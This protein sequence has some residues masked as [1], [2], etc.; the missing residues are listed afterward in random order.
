MAANSDDSAPASSS[1]WRSA[2][3][4][5]FRRGW[6]RPSSP[7]GPAGQLQTVPQDVSAVSSSEREYNTSSDAGDSHSDYP[8]YEGGPPHP[9]RYGEG[10]PSIL[11]ASP[12]GGPTVPQRVWTT[13]LLQVVWQRLSVLVSLL[14]L[15]SLSQ[16]VLEAYEGLITSNVVVPLFLTMLVGAGGNAGNQAAV[17]A[18]TG[19]V[20]G[21]LRPSHLW[22]LLRREL[23]VGLISST[24]LF[25]IGFV[26]VYLYYTNEEV[27]P[28]PV[29]A[30]VFC[31]SA[32]LFMIVL[33]SVVLGTALPFVLRK[34]KFD[35]EHAAPMIQ[36]LMD[37]LGVL[38]ACTVCA[39]FLPSDVPPSQPS[40]PTPAAQQHQQ[41]QAQRSPGGVTLLRHH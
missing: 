8:S 6:I 4:L 36:V 22:P 28:T 39:K 16:F 14:L 41:S 19:L 24:C 23:L 17:H 11:P 32:A 9:H 12:G 2:T 10:S 13:P 15:Q 34:L 7:V 29:F 40:T 37:I 18:I 26:R 30:T 38:I 33:V 3:G 5:L 21:E 1:R 25:F 35:I 31:I 20:T 27:Q